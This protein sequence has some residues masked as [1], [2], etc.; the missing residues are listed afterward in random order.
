M[1]AKKQ[2]LTEVFAPCAA[3]F[4]R[5]IT[6]QSELK[7][8]EKIRMKVEDLIEE[9]LSNSIEIFN[10]LQLFQRIGLDKIKESK[11][12]DL[13]ELKAACYYGCLLVRPINILR[14]DDEEDPRSMEEIVSA[15]GAVPVE[16]NYKTECC[17]AAHSIS[18]TDIVERLSKKII[19]N[20]LKNGADLIVV[21]CPMC[22]SNLDMRQL[23]IKKH[24]PEHKTIPIFYISQ[25]IGISMG[26]DYKKLG[27]NLHYIN[28]LPLIQKK[29]MKEAAV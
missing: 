29:I 22:H 16:W 21:A 7:R 15:A 9:K 5:L 17:G 24:N 25:L 26:I 11:K 8:D 4:S 20:A 28:P 1:L 27:M 13:S 3:C 18:H 2:G 6:S 19:D 12:I 10:V 14:F 23:N